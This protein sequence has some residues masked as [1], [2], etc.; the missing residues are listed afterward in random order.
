MTF[1]SFDGSPN[2]KIQRMFLE[3]VKSQTYQNYILAVTVFG[4]KNVPE[5]LA[6]MEIPHTLYFAPPGDYKKFSLSQVF[7]NGIRV[8]KEY[9]EECILL[10]TNADN[11]LDPDY[12]KRLANLDGPKIAG[13]SY[14]HIGYRTLDDHKTKSGGRY[15][16]YGIDSAFF[17]SDVFNEKFIEVV[18]NYPNNDYLYFEAFMVAIATVFCNT[19]INMWPAGYSVI[20]NDYKAVNQTSQSTKVTGIKNMAELKRFMR[21]FNLPDKDWYYL[22]LNYKLTNNHSIKGR[23][24]SLLIYIRIKYAGSYIRHAMPKIKKLIGLSK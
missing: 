19:R 16:W 5:T 21:D 20:T 10:W 9:P 22:I 15:G 8:S 7:L 17:S 3:T 11:I 13:I 12:F 4:E 2:D 1:R 18:K 24:M 6:E 23:I 14:P